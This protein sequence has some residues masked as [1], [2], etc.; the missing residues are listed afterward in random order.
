MFHYHKYKKKAETV[1]RDKP[2]KRFSNFH[3]RGRIRGEAAWKK[4]A[5]ISLGVVLVI[6]GGLLGLA[7]GLPG[8]FLGV[9]GIILIISRLKFAAKLMDKAEIQ[10]RK[11]IRY[12]RRES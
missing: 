11:F 4:I 10:G 7:P 6:M 1:Y 3:F 9:P 2:G 12:F 8:F 5:Y